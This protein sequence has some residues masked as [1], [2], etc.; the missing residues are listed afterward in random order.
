MILGVPIMAVLLA[1]IQA[2]INW[3]RKAEKKEEPQEV[4]AEPVGAETNEAQ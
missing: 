1:V 3:D 4:A 2:A